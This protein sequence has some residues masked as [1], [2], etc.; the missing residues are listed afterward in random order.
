MFCFLIY[1]SVL[2]HNSSI[3][4]CF[5]GGGV[6]VECI[7]KGYTIVVVVI[8]ESRGTKGQIIS[9]LNNLTIF[10]VVVVVE[11]WSNKKGSIC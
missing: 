5:G 4:V 10:L 8:V 3:P 9:L 6:F 2:F 7:F 11:R 1:S